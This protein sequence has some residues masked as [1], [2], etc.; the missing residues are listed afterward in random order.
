MNLSFEKDPHEWTNTRM[1][2]ELTPLGSGTL[3]HFT[4]EDLVPEKDC[5]SKCTQGW[6]MVIKEKLYNFINNEDGAI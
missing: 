3:L 6:D 1:I 5:Y 4:H 2:F